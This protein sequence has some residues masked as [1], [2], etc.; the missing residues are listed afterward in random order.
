MFMNMF[1]RVVFCDLCG[2]GALQL[3]NALHTYPRAF[4]PAFNAEHAFHTHRTTPIQYTQALQSKL[5]QLEF[6]NA[7]SA[8]TSVVC[9]NTSTSAPNNTD[10]NNNNV[11]QQ[12]TQLRLASESALGDMYR[13]HAGEVS[14][15]V[16]AAFMWN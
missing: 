1:T 13:R 6:A 14:E 9:T 15:M 7:S 3:F 4:L 2:N 12:Q 5:K 16:C 11:Q 8:G 10:N